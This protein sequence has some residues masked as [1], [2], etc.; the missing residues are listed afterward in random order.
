MDSA[1]QCSA[2]RFEVDRN[3]ATILGREAVQT[4]PG[5]ITECMITLTSNRPG[6]MRRFQVE[7]VRGSVSD[8]GVHFHMYDGPDNTGNRIVRQKNLMKFGCPLGKTNCTFTVVQIV[9]SLVLG[10]S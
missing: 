9:V 4:N 6:E 3:S 1:S 5:T 2:K 10:N 7:I 8:A